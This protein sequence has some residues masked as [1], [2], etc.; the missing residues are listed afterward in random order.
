MRLATVDT[1]L[2]NS[3]VCGIPCVTFC[4]VNRIGRK[5]VWIGPDEK[6]K[7]EEKNCIGCGICVH[8]CPFDAI[9]IVNLAD[10]LDKMLIHRYGQNAFALYGLPEIKLGYVTG[11][12][13]RNGA[14]K[15]TSLNILS[16]RLTPNFGGER[17]DI[18][19]FF[20]G[21]E[22][23]AY[24]EGLGSGSIR[25]STK[26]QLVE[27]STVSGASLKSLL[28]E[29]EV[30][31][32][33]AHSLIEKLGLGYLADRSLEQLSGGELQLVL[34]AH[35][36]SKDADVY[37][38][39]EPSSYL[40]VYQRMQA[41]KAIRE[42]A[43]SGKTVAVVEH[44]LIVLDYLSDYVSVVYGV[45][46]AFGLASKAYGTRNGINNFLRGYL[47][48]ENMKLREGSIDFFDVTLEKPETGPLSLSWGGMS[49]ALGSFRLEV[50]EGTA[51]QS[52][53]V[54]LLGRNGTGKTTFVR[55]LAGILKPDLGETPIGMRVSYKPQMLHP[56]PGTVRDI[57]R[58]VEQTKSS[59]EVYEEDVYQALGIERLLNRELSSLSGGELQKVAVALCLGR[60]A[61]VF[62]LDEPSAFLDVE[63]R[64]RVGK[65]VRRLVAA[66]KATAFVVDHDLLLLTYISD[67]L[68]KFDGE[69]GKWGRA[70]HPSKVLDGVNAFLKEVGITMRRDP[71]TGRPRVNKDGSVLDRQQ[72]SSG[73]YFMVSAE[74]GD[75]VEG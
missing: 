21:S 58:E 30:N 27:E 37:I 20:R 47:P 36:L 54:A 52:S 71:D 41:A 43:S 16:G 44:D 60:D 29:K 1:S 48:E 72:K 3:K 51:R 26:P 28:E 66:K 25:V 11:I 24:F 5:T 34:L 14:G 53:V 55:M 62:L 64:L 10:A 67:S 61:E 40:D 73:A 2:C 18:S 32:E 57:M 70:R 8:K 69:S 33:K 75:H 56:I 6:A 23:K 49:K 50:E 65:A 15:S 35:A 38:I 42:T 39:D 9:N 17:R 7:I 68:I 63:E 4:P 13:G 46:G 22:L 31:K 59:S 12:V 45:P 74:R 19:S